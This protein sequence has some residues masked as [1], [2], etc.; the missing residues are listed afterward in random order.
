ML[1]PENR[2]AVEVW[3][4]VQNQVLVGGMG[5]VIDINQLAVWEA[6]D[7]YG[8]LKPIHCFESVCYLFDYFREP[9][10]DGN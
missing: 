7:R 10:T 9:V 3:K 8:V 5:T 4:R 2:E 6:I 1:D